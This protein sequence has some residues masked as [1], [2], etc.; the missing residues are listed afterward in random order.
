V[1]GLESYG[2][3]GDVEA[4]FAPFAV[5]GLVAGRV[6]VEHKSRYV[7]ATG[8]GERAAR[9]AGKLRYESG[10]RVELPAVG[11]WVAL[12][13][14]HQGGE[15]LIH[16]VVPRTGAFTRR[17]AGRHGGT[18][19]LA[20]NVDVVF[21]VASLTRELNARRLERYLTLAWESGASPLV[22]LNKADLC[23][24]VPGAVG[25]VESVT[26]G[27]PVHVAS[28]RTGSGVEELRHHLSSHR[29]GALLGSSG[30]GKSTLVNRLCGEE[31]QAV[32]EVRAGDLKGR[33]T[34][35]RREL[36]ILPGGGILIDTPGMRELQLSEAEGG[37]AAAFSDITE[38]AE[39]CAFGDC[40]HGPEPGCAVSLAVLEGRLDAERLEG[41]RK[42]MREIERHER[43]YD[44]RKA[45]QE[46]QKLRAIHRAHR[47]HTRRKRG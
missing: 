13:C 28:A 33:H 42:L 27:V 44:K 10:D 25:T 21:I 12:R 11:D 38:L 40:R 24:D 43:D 32:R 34:T 23:D 39:E 9:C 31:R 47:D 18:Q 16:A 15:A 41:W 6:V 17:A 14:P 8:E 4:R 35:T 46:R 26:A 7:V 2:W 19:V 22:V 20:A 45:A 36:I 1:S 5:G 37:L 30:V 29:T 3:N